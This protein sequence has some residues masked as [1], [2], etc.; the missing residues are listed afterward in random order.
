MKRMLKPCYWA[1]LRR[2]PASAAADRITFYTDNNF[3]GRQFS[4]DQ[5]IS[6]FARDG[7]NDRVSSAVVHEGRW[8]ICL[9]ADY[10]GGAAF[11]RRA[12]IPTWAP[13]PIA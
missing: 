7:L 11:S 12:R 8:E 9:D 13:M 1:S 5:P 4:A 2:P 6:D 10:R 3:G